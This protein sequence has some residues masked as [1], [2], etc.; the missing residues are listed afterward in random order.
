MDEA[1]KRLIT[2]SEVSVKQ[3]PP[4]DVEIV[5]TIKLISLEKLFCYFSQD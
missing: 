2:K 4:D 5:S 1:G 3:N